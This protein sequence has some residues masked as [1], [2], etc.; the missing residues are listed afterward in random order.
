MN[1]NVGVNVSVCNELGGSALKQWQTRS[2]IYCAM[3]FLGEQAFVDV[4]IWACLK[5][6]LRVCC[7][8]DLYL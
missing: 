3:H 8:R 2:I 1:V 7:G 5:Q 6:Q 4:I